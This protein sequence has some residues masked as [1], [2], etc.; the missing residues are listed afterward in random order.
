[1]SISNIVYISIYKHFKYI[2]VDKPCKSLYKCIQAM[3]VF[4]SVQAN[5][6]SVYINMGKYF[7]FLSVYPS[8]D[9][10]C[11]CLLQF[12]QTLLVS[13]SV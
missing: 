6:V 3:E 1:M 13:T 9:K 12:R 7:N 10:P 11:N 4:I 8:I 2:I 5:F